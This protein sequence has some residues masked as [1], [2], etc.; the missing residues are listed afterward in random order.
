MLLTQG[1]GPVASEH[2]QT[3]SND[4]AAARKA[5]RLPW[6][7]AAGSSFVLAGLLAVAAAL[8][9]SFTDPEPT[10]GWVVPALLGGAVAFA[11]AGTIFVLRAIRLSRDA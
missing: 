8:T 5:E 11:V 1:D 3:S 6:A 2:P 7:L 9:A 4:S 10:P